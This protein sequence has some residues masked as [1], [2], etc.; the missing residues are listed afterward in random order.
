MSPAIN[1]VITALLLLG[2]F[3]LAALRV[4]YRRLLPRDIATLEGASAGLFFFR[5]ISR[6]VWAKK[7]V[8]TTH[9]CLMCTSNLLRFCY[10]MTSV[11][12]LWLLKLPPFQP[13]MPATPADQ[14][15]ISFA[16]L[17]GLFVVG[18]LCGDYL[19]RFVAT[20][21]PKGA[22][23]YSAP[24][25]SAY[26]LVALP[27]SYPLYTV[28]RS[29]TKID[30]L[31]QDDDPTTQ[32]GQE[33]IEL[34]RELNITGRFD[35]HDKKLI[36]SVVNFRHQ[37][38]K[39][40]MVPRVDVFSLPGKMSIREATRLLDPEGYSRIPV[41]GTSIDEIKGVLMHKDILR[42][43]MESEATG[44]PAILDAP[45]ETI[46]KEVMFTPETKKLSLL[47]QEF[48]NK[49]VHLA[50]VVDEYGGTEGIVTIED[51]LEQIVGEIADEYDE[52][53]ALFAEKAEGGWIVDARM[54]ILDV[55][56]KLDVR[57][58][59]EGDYDTLAGFVFHCAGSIPAKGFVIH[60]DNLDLEV[61][62]SNDR[63]V[64][65]IWLKPTA[66]PNQQNGESH[67][68]HD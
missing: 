3:L 56:E 48:R 31:D 18:F 28:L 50:I 33:L 25:G 16:T 19:P 41:Y 65:K 12:W 51:I 14:W 30:R 32:F 47:L 61:L 34:L 2:L 26:M 49:Q 9:F 64:E 45:I 27:I 11:A 57:I 63:M 39:E 38:A 5:P 67:H 8:E 44:N 36:E 42:K 54:S 17:L 66:P 46:V 29:I 10:A 24:I 20:R 52:D 23:R 59:E 60:R 55:E 43:H 4:A 6:L 37:L 22:L 7:R 1:L 21:F 68:H 13:E 40:I 53:E 15:L 58:P 35:A 62:S